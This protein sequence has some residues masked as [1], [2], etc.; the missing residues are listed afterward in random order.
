VTEVTLPDLAKRQWV[1]VWAHRLLAVGLVGASVWYFIGSL[2]GTA[3]PVPD[4]GLLPRPVE[5]ALDAATALTIAGIGV[6]VWFGV[7][8][9]RDQGAVPFLLLPDLGAVGLALI[10][11]SGGASEVLALWGLLGLALTSTALAVRVLPPV[12]AEA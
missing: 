11:L 9:W 12:L 3:G 6:L 10:G 8:R 7:R 4:D 2:A 1:T 5:I